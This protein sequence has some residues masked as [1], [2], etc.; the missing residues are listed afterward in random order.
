MAAQ[1][2]SGILAHCISFLIAS[3]LETSQVGA[4]DVAFAMFEVVVCSMYVSVFEALFAPFSLHR[5]VW[6]LEVCPTRYR[7]KVSVL[8][9][10]FSTVH[11]L[12]RRRC[13]QLSES[14]RAK[15]Q[16]SL[17]KPASEL[18]NTLVSRSK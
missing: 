11:L 3:D 15:S 8:D 16:D 14:Q 7:S 4:G 17:P 18:V 12:K 5:F 6:L 1:L 9:G 13:K 10:R 2:S